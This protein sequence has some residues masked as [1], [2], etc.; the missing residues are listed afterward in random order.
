MYVPHPIVSLNRNLIRENLK[1]CLLSTGIAY[2][3]LGDNCGA[4]VEDPSCYSNGKVDY[5]LVAK[6]QNF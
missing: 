1:K 6:D 5:N 2:V 4:R 3:F